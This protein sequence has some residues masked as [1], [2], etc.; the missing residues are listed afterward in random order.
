MCEIQLETEKILF[1]LKYVYPL[2]Q[3]I[4]MLQYKALKQCHNCFNRDVG[5]I[6]G[7]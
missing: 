5:A 3:C 7:F 2:K 1:L 4:S 6:N